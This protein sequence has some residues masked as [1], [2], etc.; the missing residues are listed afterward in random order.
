MLNVK[1]FSIHLWSLRKEMAKYFFV[2]VSGLAVDMGLLI[3][4][5]EL[6]G[7]R[8]LFALL[9]SQSG[10]LTYNFTLNK[11]WSFKNNVFTHREVVRYGLLAGFNYLFSAVC[12]HVFAERYQ[13][14]Y[15]LVRLATIACMV[16]WNFFLYKYWVYRPSEPTIPTSTAS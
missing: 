9:I 6:L 12:M 4:A 1:M 5:K 8:P 2:G 3:F 15:R 10:A 14:D 16:S 13:V 7:L 11:Y